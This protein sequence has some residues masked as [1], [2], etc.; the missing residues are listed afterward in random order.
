MSKTSE[1]NP[2]ALDFLAR[3]HSRFAREG[4]SQADGPILPLQTG[5]RTDQPATSGQTLRLLLVDDQ[6][7]DVDRWLK[8]LE[9][10]FASA[11]QTQ[12]AH[13]AAQA[14]E[15]LAREP[16]DVVLTEY[17]LPDADG[18]GLVASITAR[19]PEV[20]T[21]LV[22]SQGSETVAA[23]ALRFGARDYLVKS[24]LD[25][26]TLHRSIMQA[27]SK[28][29]ARSR[30]QSLPPTAKKPEQSRHEMDHFV[31]SLSHDMTAMFMLL[32]HSFQRL[33][34]AA[35]PTAES[36]RPKLAGSSIVAVQP[37][38]VAPESQPIAALGPLT[39]RF[40]HVEACLRESKRFLDDL[41]TVARTGTVQM[42][43]S[44]VE[45]P[46]IV[47]EVLFEQRELLAERDVQVERAADLPAV[48]CNPCRVKQVLTNLSRETR[49]TARPRPAAAADLD[50]ALP[51]ARSGR[52]GVRVYRDPR[53]WPWHSARIAGRNFRARP[54]PFR[55]PSRRHGH[56][57][58][59]CPQ[60]RAALRRGRIRG[61]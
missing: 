15:I 37:A 45:L 39:Q 24:E 4:S 16:T 33:K 1:S 23:N 31:R 44:R 54:T 17:R 20:A 21:I 52:Y 46:I 60:D 27:A 26:A 25:A 14:L 43:P 19:Y 13:S 59:D 29:S 11:A 18:L 7:Q 53:Q 42:E 48:W 57:P 2:H 50:F 32:D 22:T 30:E 47:E 28:A 40:A 34:D 35:E 8:M 58:V 55:G 38:I 41:T 5:W 6:P 49:C 56:G 51:V 36:A 10:R 12:V 3:P 61:F 9:E